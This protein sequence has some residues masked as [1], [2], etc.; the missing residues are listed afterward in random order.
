MI[1][2]RLTLNKREQ[3]RLMVLN[4]LERGEVGLAGAAEVLRVSE[5]QVWRMLSAY[6]KEGAEGLAHGNRGRKP[7][8]TLPLTVREEVVSLAADKYTGFNHTHLTEKLDEVE[9]T[10]LSR[11]SVRRILLEKGMRSPRKHRSTLHRRRRERSPREGM[12]L[13]TDG[14]PHDWLEGRGP[15]LCLIGAIDDA[16]NKVPYAHFCE[17]ETTEGYMLML[18]EIVLR[19]GIPAAIYHDR[20]SIFEIPR[21]VLPSL[22]EQLAGKEPRSQFGRLLDELGIESIAANSPQ[23]KG[24][25]ERLWSTFQDRLISELRLAGA[26]TI[27]EANAVLARFLLEY[28]RRFAIPAREPETA[29]IKPGGEF[30]PEEYFCLKEK[31]T[32]GD[33][34]VVRYYDQRLQVLPLDG[35]TGLVGRKV[36]V[37]L[38]LDHTLAVYC[39]GERMETRPA[40]LE[41]TAARKQSL[42]PAEPGKETNKPA[43]PE[44]QKPAPDHPWRG[45]FRTHFD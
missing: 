29:Y 15:K 31:R 12:M 9:G 26:S 4:R 37:Q 43:N 33:D 28:N 23:A 21:S 39:R 42:N 35:K 24:R 6:R 8:N 7:A 2:E 32:I 41:A 18:R 27:E 34:N 17:K 44:P 36:E 25:I 19:E 13:Q 22:E 16:T 30:K 38:R 5:R 14:S 40:P 10:R 45:K 11:S 3:V 1:R 20:H